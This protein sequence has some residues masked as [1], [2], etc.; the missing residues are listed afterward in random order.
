MR[1]FLTNA[2]SRNDSVRCVNRHF[3]FSSHDC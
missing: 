1:W 3:L 2:C